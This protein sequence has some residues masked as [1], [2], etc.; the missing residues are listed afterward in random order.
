MSTWCWLH[1]RPEDGGREGLA[2]STAALLYLRFSDRTL[3]NRS[4]QNFLEEIDTGRFASNVATFHIICR[5]CDYV[6]NCACIV[7]ISQN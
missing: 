6:H 5:I 1:A 2:I 4:L 7:I 3:S